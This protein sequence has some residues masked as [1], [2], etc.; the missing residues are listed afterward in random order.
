MPPFLGEIRDSLLQ[1]RR[2][3]DEAPGGLDVAVLRQELGQLISRVEAELSRDEGTNALE[4]YERVRLLEPG[5]DSLHRKWSELRDSVAAEAADALRNGLDLEA[6]WAQRW[7]PLF[8][9]AWAAREAARIGSVSDGKARTERRVPVGDP[10]LVYDLRYGG[11]MPYVQVADLVGLSPAAVQLRI[12]EFEEGVLREFGR[13][14]VERQVPEGWRI[15]GGRDAQRS[16][17]VRHLMLRRAGAG[18]AEILISL[19]PVRDDR[20]TSVGRPRSAGRIDVAAARFAGPIVW[21]VILESGPEVRFLPS[22]AVGAEDQERQSFA[23]LARSHGHAV[24]A[25]A[26]ASAMQGGPMT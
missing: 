7:G 10:S 16:R 23:S 15:A 8:E 4:R 19:V 17:G 21:A 24:L 18:A 14:A 1:L 11:G 5:F 25:D 2:A 26:I 9:V 6:G 3:L 12:S 13:Q 20:E 22:S